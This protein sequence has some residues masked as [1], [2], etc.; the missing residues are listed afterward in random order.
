MTL[1]SAGALRQSP[2]PTPLLSRRA[3]VAEETSDA[4]DRQSATRLSRTGKRRRKLIAIRDSTIAVLLQP[5]ELPLGTIEAV[6]PVV[7]QEGGTLVASRPADMTGDSRLV[8]IQGLDITEVSH[9]VEV[10]MY[11]ITGVSHQIA[12]SLQIKTQL[13]EITGVIRQ[14]V[15][16]TNEVVVGRQVEILESNTTEANHQVDIMAEGIVSFHR[17]VN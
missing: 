8:E 5:E 4:A 6:R 16:Q 11:E 7:R 17:P 15:V 3:V 1:A 10:Q 13:Y 2:P 14:I 12:V 9:Q